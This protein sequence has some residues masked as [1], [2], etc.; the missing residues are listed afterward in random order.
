MLQCIS[1]CRGL[2]NKKSDWMVCCISYWNYNWTPVIMTYLSPDSGPCQDE[3][4]SPCSRSV[5]AATSVTTSFSLTSV[6]TLSGEA[7][8]GQNV[9]FLFCIIMIKNYPDKSSH[10]DQVNFVVRLP[11]SVQLTPACS[12][13]WVSNHWTL[14]LESDCR[15][16]WLG[17]LSS[18]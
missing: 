10:G 8:S 14:E 12:D 16:V 17:T 1:M 9:I 5:I 13:V 7:F 18:V 6:S 2:A 4:L 11:W 15:L 3:S